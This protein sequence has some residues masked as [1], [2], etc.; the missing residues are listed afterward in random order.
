M[1][2]C[3]KMCISINYRISI[4]KKPDEER[5]P[6]VFMYLECLKMLFR[7]SQA[8]VS[9]VTSEYTKLFEYQFWWA[10]AWSGVEKYERQ[11][12]KSLQHRNTV[13]T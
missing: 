4:K 9:Y 13:K 6:F 3:P 7:P 12:V 5:L 1:V 11:T 8:H 10:L 2:L